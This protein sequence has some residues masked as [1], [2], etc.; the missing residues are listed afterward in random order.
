MSKTPQNYDI[1]G[2]NQHTFGKKFN[3][4]HAP[5]VNVAPISGLNA[6]QISNGSHEEDLNKVNLNNLNTPRELS[7]KK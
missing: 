6:I 5:L 2:R 1:R 4:K 3:P 7:D